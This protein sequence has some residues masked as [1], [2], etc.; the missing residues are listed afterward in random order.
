MTS[1]RTTVG[2]VTLV[3]D[4]YG[5][6]DGPPAL[7]FHGGGQT[8]HSWKGAAATLGERGWYAA[9]YDLRGHGESDWSPDGLYGTHVFGDDVRHLAL[10]QS[11]PPALVGASLGGIASLLAIAAADEADRERVAAALV[12]VDVAPRLE[13]AGVTKIGLFMRSGLDGFDSLDD[14]ADAIAAYNPNRPRPTDLSGL[15]KNVR[16]RADGKWVWH[17]DPRFLQPRTID[18]LSVDEASYSHERRLADAARKVTCPTLL[19]RGRESDVLSEDGARNLLSLIPHAEYVDVSGAGHMVAGD[20]NDWFS[21]AVVEFLQ[22]VL[23]PR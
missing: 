17:W 21:D 23:P 5:P 2:D 15:R 10:A 1:I 9:S 16:Q 7:L 13:T 14:V 22:R 20:R 18:G 12:L 3:A 4:V 19:V 11:R 6:P 8:R